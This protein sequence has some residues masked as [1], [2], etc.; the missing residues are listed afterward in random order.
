MVDELTTLPQTLGADQSQAPAAQP[1]QTPPTN[2]SGF[3]EDLIKKYPR[4]N[5]KIQVDVSTYGLM[6]DGDLKAQTLHI[7]PFG[8]E[9]QST[10][11]YAQ[12]T[13]LK[14]LVALPDYWQRKQRFVEYRRIDTPDT[15]KIL[16][17]V[18]RTEEVGKRGKKKLV[19]VQTV[20][21]DE[22]D[23]QVLKSFLQDG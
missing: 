22:I 18:V 1:E 2:S 20:N 4:S 12:G 16:A 5:R 6:Q 14:I 11:D 21:M 10:K 19:V 3:N 8:M 7:S 15:F 23:E 17:K 9:I 13:L